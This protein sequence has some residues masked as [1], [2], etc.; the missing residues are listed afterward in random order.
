M[1]GPERN[2]NSVIAVE[3]VAEKA[4]QAVP[5]FWKGLDVN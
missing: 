1:L 4:A 2:K 3:I 5:G